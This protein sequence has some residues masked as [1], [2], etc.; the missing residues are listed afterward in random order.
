[1][2]CVPSGTSCSGGGS[3]GST[4]GSGSGGSGGSGSGSCTTD[5][6]SS[7]GNAFFQNYCNNCHGS[8]YASQSNVQ[9]QLNSVYSSISSGSMPT[10]GLSSSTRTR[11]LNYL[12]CGAP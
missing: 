3:G 5:T 2:N 11:I 10:G 4:G 9:A 8:K 7:F 6:W 1:M 12:N